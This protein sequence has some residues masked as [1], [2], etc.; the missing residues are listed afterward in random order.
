M[1]TS[2]KDIKENEKDQIPEIFFFFFFSL[3]G[4]SKL[5]RTKI[6]FKTNVSPWTDIGV[7][8]LS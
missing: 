8:V 5:I 6:L 7:D 3:H 4:R 1:Y 2:I